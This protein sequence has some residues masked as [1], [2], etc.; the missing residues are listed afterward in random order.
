[1]NST[2]SWPPTICE[3]R[4]LVSDMGC[5]WTR[6]AWGSVGDRGDQLQGVQLAAHPLPKR[7]VDQL[8][9]LDAAHAGE[10]GRG[11]AGLVV[12]AVVDQ[13]D[14]LDLGVGQRGLDQGFNLGRGHR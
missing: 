2:T 8:V 13:R 4:A 6:I 7:L 12:V 9:L 5:T 10:R 14:D 1:M 11:D 3:R